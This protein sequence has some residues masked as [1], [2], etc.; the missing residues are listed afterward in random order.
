MYDYGVIQ[1]QALKEIILTRNEPQ[2]K[3]F[4]YE[5]SLFGCMYI[6]PLQHSI[7]YAFEKG[8]EFKTSVYNPD[9]VIKIILQ[10]EY[11]LVYK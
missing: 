10:G 8:H 5:M 2:K 6:R 1:V 7:Y 4:F 3:R 11:Y 9:Y